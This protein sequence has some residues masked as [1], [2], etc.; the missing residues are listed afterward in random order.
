MISANSPYILNAAISNLK[1]HGNEADFIGF[2]HKLFPH[3]SLTLPFEPFLFWLRIRA[4]IRN[5]KAT[6]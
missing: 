2:L 4:D 3:R 1:G 5:R 6:P